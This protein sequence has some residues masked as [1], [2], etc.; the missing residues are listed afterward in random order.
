MQYNIW[1]SGNGNGNGNSNGLGIIEYLC[2]NIKT[3]RDEGIVNL[4][5]GPNR[6]PKTSFIQEQ[7]RDQLLVPDIPPPPHMVGQIENPPDQD[8]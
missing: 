1:S 2:Y 7:S 8:K 3:K 5:D 6:T 4:V